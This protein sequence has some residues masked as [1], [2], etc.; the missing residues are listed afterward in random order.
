M[1]KLYKK[2]SRRF[3]SHMKVLLKGK[4]TYGKYWQ[5]ID[6]EDYDDMFEATPDLHKNFMNFLQNKTDVKTVL[7]VGC[8]NGMYPIK[9]KELFL[10]KDYEGIDFGKPAIEYCKKN[11]NFKFS[12]GD[13]IKMKLDKK[14][15]LVF[16]HAVIDHVYDIEGFL[17]KIVEACKKY[18][19]VSSYRGYFPDLQ[20]HSMRWDDGQGCYYNDLSVEE[21][22]R[23]LRKCGL[24]EDEFNIRKQ[25]SGNLKDN[26]EEET[27]IEIYRKNHS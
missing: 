27:V 25:K 5:E 14:Y 12:Q 22:K 15:D 10:N 6:L 3:L 2:V 13:F 9:F 11:S 19:L 26:I 18:A 20:K 16:S 23:N 8:G 21:T 4:A 24:S 17:F 1:P 7:E